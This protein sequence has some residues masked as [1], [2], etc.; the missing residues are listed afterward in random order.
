MNAHEWLMGGARREQDL[1]ALGGELRRLSLLLVAW[2]RRRARGRDFALPFDVAF[3]RFG[4][5]YS[6]ED[7]P[8][9]P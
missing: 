3:L 7:L 5:D 9:V 6:E 4:P 8:P 2:E 1:Q